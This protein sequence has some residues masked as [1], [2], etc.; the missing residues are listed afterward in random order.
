VSDTPEQQTKWLVE[1]A[2]FLQEHDS[3]FAC[4]CEPTIEYDVNAVVHTE[5]C[6]TNY[7]D[8]ADAVLRQA[9][10]LITSQET[11][12]AALIEA[13]AT[14]IFWIEDAGNYGAPTKDEILP[15]LRAA[16]A[17]LYAE[18]RRTPDC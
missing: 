5:A 10:W 16:L 13:P 17:P 8:H 4:N 9:A 3:S 2:D 14:A 18:F 15:Q 1:I 12:R 6:A 11:R 7:Q